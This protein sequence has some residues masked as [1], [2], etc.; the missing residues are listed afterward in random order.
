M[1]KFEI[2][3]WDE[4]TQGFAPNP[5][6]ISVVLTREPNS[7]AHR[8]DVAIT[9]VVTLRADQWDAK[10][11]F[12]N[13]NIHTAWTTAYGGTAL[14]EHLLAER[15]SAATMMAIGALHALVPDAAQMVQLEAQPGTIASKYTG[16]VLTDAFG[17][18]LR[19]LGPVNRTEREAAEELRQKRWLQLLRITVTPSGGGK[20]HVHEAYFAPFHAPLVPSDEFSEAAIKLKE[21]LPK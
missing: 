3:Y 19:I 15:M 7:N 4:G 11:Q 21:R 6:T 18:R 12:V 2:A 10:R 8:V 5:V 13:E 14:R 9:D 20:Q 16:K 17:N 1:I